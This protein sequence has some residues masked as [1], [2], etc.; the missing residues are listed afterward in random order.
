MGRWASSFEPLCRRPFAACYLAGSPRRRVTR[1]ALEGRARTQSPDDVRPTAAAQPPEHAS[2][3][4]YPRP[5]QP[6]EQSGG[7]AA[8]SREPPPPPPTL[9]PASSCAWPAA[10]VSQSC[11]CCHAFMSGTTAKSLPSSDSHPP[12]PANSAYNSDHGMAGG[13]RDTE[14]APD[15]LQGHP[16]HQHAAQPGDVHSLQKQPGAGHAQLVSSL[17]VLLSPRLTTMSDP[18]RLD[19]LLLPPPPRHHQR[20]HRQR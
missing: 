12:P 3:A 9:P 11:E 1:R 17:A 8:T 7:P 6:G 20:P 18:R 5:C 14:P 4:K 15:R 19:R 13:R 10:D 2:D 16:R